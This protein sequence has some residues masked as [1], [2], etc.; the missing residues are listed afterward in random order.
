MLRAFYRSGEKAAGEG[1]GGGQVEEGCG[2]PKGIRS[3]FRDRFR[4]PP[5]RVALPEWGGSS[6]SALVLDI[7]G[8]VSAG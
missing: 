3:L 4:C 6:W 7:R 1:P 2:V 5:C 8:I